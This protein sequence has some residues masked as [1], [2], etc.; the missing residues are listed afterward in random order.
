[1]VALGQDVHVAGE[2]LSDVVALDGSVSIT[3]RVAGDVIVLGGGATL[4]EA[5][6]VAGD[7]FVLGGT[8]EV[9]PG[10]VIDGRTVS[11][12]TVSSA[13]LTLLEGPSLG[14]PATSPLVVGAKLALLAGWL[15]LSLVLF[16]TAGREM[17]HTS[18]SVA[19][20]PFRNFLVGLTAVLTL[21]LTALFLTTLA[22]SL[23][24]I[25]MLFL[26]ALLA[27]LLKLW[28][29]VAVFHALGG[30]LSRRLLGQRLLPL[31]TVTVGLMLLGIVR[32]LPWLG[33][34]AWTVATFVGVG[35]ALTTKFGR[36][37]P[38]LAT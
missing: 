15:A 8:V 29:M 10:A 1:V 20:D 7:V 32:L 31:T 14:L 2:A 17:L 3:G 37:E 21:V 18:E 26:V 11:Y 23:V 25:P 16:A 34:W 13:W 35:A 9:A 12:P 28:G 4:G 24:A 36:R 6:R 33:V 5:A 27:I 38:W 30:W 19:Q 22:A